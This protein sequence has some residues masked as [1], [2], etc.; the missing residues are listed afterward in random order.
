MPYDRDTYS[1]RTPL[2]GVAFDFMVDANDFIADKIFT[3][4]PAD[5]SKKKVAQFDTSKLKVVETRKK[6]DSEADLVDEQLFYRDIDLE[7]HKLG[8][9]INPQNVANADN[10]RLLDEARGVRLVTNML[11]MKRE[12]LAATLVTTASNYPSDLTAALGSGSRWHEAGGDP[13]ADKV[14]AD[15][16]LRNRCGRK[17]NAM[18]LD[19]NVYD[20]LCTSPSFRE[21]VMYGGSAVVTDEHIKAFFKVQHLFVGNARRDAAVEGAAA[22]IDGFWGTGVLFFVHDPSPDEEAMSYGH[23]Y[24]KNTPFWTKVTEDDKRTGPNGPM[25]LVQVGTEYVMDKGFVVS[26]S[27]SDFA[28]GYLLRTVVA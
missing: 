14:T 25:K 8:K 7:E 23:L 11:L 2:E 28:A 16:A 12:E 17:A 9:E 26:S 19:G 10:P 22:S 18:A 6:T 5:K 20:R 21:R 13:E 24:V 3:P 15:N 4:K 1:T 27:D